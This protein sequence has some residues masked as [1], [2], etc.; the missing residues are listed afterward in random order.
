MSLYERLPS[1]KINKAAWDACVH[2]DPIGLV[3][4]FSWYLDIVAPAWEGIVTLEKEN[5][6]SLVMPLPMRHIMGKSFISQPILMQQLGIFSD[7]SNRKD[8]NLPLL[9]LFAFPEGRSV[10][11]YS[12]HAADYNEVNALLPLQKRVNY[13]L[14][15]NQTYADIYQHYSSNRVRDLKKA[16]KANLIFREG[17]DLEPAVVQLL[18]ENLVPLLNL[19]QQVALLNVMPTLISE[20][21]NRGL[22]RIVAVFLPNKQIVAAAFFIQYKNRLTYLL[23]AANAPGKKVGA[24]TFLLDTICRKEAG[25]NLIIDFEGSSLPGI[26]HFYQSLGAQPETYGLLVQHRY[27]KWLRQIKK[28]RNW[29]F[30]NRPN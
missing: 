7:K 27:P 6:Y 17:N 23:P 25:T 18:H 16:V 5:T 28:I 13:I 2:R 20:V 22:A 3:Y 10:E 4:A 15:L 11:H 30:K 12:F 29:L 19:K 8:L 26:A 14:P 9:L 21:R 1:N 24:S